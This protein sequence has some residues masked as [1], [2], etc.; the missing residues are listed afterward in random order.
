[1]IKSK[2]SLIKLS[3]L[4]IGVILTAALTISAVVINTSKAKYS[5][6]FEMEADATLADYSVDFTVTYGTGGNARSYKSESL[7]QT[8]GVIRMT[9][10]EYSTMKLMLNHSSYGWCYLRFKIT[11]SWQHK[12]SSGKD[13]ITPKELS[14]YTLDGSMYD[15][16]SIDGY[17][18]C[19]NI[20]KLTQNINAITKCVPGN[21]AVDL[22]SPTDAAQFVD[23]SV[24]VE[25]VQWNQAK[26]MWGLTKLPWE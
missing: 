1:M 25:A 26:E 24:E 15:N 23:V 2:K 8:N 14:V 6:Q 13:I 17:I 9:A 16:R 18:Y 10:S 21:D 4:L 3:V 5:D 22:L 11:E 19:K 12:D 20:L 7:K